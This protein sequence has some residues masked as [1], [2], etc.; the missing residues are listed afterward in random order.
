MHYY[1]YH[2]YYYYYHYYYDYYYYYAEEIKADCLNPSYGGRHLWIYNRSRS[3]NSTCGYS[4]LN[5]D[6]REE[7]A[8]H[9]C[10]YIDKNVT[11]RL[12][13]VHSW[14][15]FSTFALEVPNDHFSTNLCKT[16]KRTFQ[17]RGWEWMSFVEFE[18]LYLAKWKPNSN[19]PWPAWFFDNLCLQERCNQRSVLLEDLVLLTH[20]DFSARL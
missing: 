1:Y 6:R 4:N 10:L 18:F 19:N 11:L 8:C 12:K 2:Y 14:S 9:T 3:R 5:I 17:L 7:N 16:N 20:N 15:G 13:A